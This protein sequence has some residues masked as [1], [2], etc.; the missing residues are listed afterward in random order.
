[1]KTDYLSCRIAVHID[2]HNHD[3]RDDRD[4]PD[5][6]DDV[7]VDDQDLQKRRWGGRITQRKERVINILS[8]FSY[9]VLLMSMS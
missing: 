3:G 2:G 6:P 1:M 4:D 5:D 8:W 9:W 7:R